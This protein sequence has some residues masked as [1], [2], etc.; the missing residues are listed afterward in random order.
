[1]RKHAWTARY[2]LCHLSLTSD[3]FLSLS[4]F[5]RLAIL[6]RANEKNVLPER[7]I[8]LGVTRKAIQ[9]YADAQHIMNAERLY[10]YTSMLLK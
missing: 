5:F 7:G 9:R 6:N 4:L 2:R 1:V 10:K 8:K 3:L